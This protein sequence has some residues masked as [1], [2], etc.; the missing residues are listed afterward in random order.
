MATLAVLSDFNSERDDWV[1]IDIVG[2]SDRQTHA[3]K[4]SHVD[5]P[6]FSALTSHVI[7]DFSA[8][9]QAAQRG[10]PTSL[11]RQHISFWIVNRPRSLS[12]HDCFFQ[13]NWQ[14]YIAVARKSFY[15]T[16]GSQ[17]SQSTQLEIW[18]IGTNHSRSQQMG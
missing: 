12:C 15:S 17:N 7:R 5:N 4:S 16:K 11:V 9:A 13:K 2:I 18:Y 3:A 8:I 14:R 6:S 1:Q 10:R